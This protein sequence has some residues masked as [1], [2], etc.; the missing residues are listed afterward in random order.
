M[1]LEVAQGHF[2]KDASGTPNATQDINL[3]FTPTALILWCTF[4]TSMGFATHSNFSHGFSDGTNHWSVATWSEDGQ[5]TSD[6]HRRH[7]AKAITILDN[8]GTLTCEADVAFSATKFTLTWTTNDAIAVRIHYLA[9]GGDVQAHVGS[10]VSAASPV[11]PQD[12]AITGVGFVPQCV[13]FN[14]VEMT[15]SPPGT[16]TAGAGMG[17][18]WACGSGSGDQN[19]FG[20]WSRDNQVTTNTVRYWRTA[21]CISMCSD[22]GGGATLPTIVC[23]MKSFDADGF[24][25]T[26][27]AAL[28]IASYQG[29]LALRGAQFD[30]QEL[31]TPVATGTRALTGA[32]FQ[33]KGALW[34]SHC[35]TAI[36]PGTPSPVAHARLGFGAS[37]DDGG[38]PFPQGHSWVGDTTNLANSSS[39]RRHS[40][41]KYLGIIDT[42][43]PVAADEE[44]ALD[45]YDADGLTEDWTTV[46]AGNARYYST[47]LIGEAVA[48]Y[49]HSQGIII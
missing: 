16:G 22:K 9:L 17:L 46:D 29:Y 7:A 47:L 5:A 44:A 15:T 1:S 20:I 31:Q 42:D 11:P 27:Q 28:A 13:M 34:F 26:H 41:L 32:G 14:T 37:Y 18:G 49:V 23:E 4:Q 48:G 43:N 19:A 24:T 36:S 39:D 33:P 2:G 40:V 3:S 10:F 12:Q 35:S 6:C 30:V 45:S 25:I 21:R 8:T 38:A